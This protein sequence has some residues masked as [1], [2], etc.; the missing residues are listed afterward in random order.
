MPF[1]GDVRSSRVNGFHIR[2]E[3][4][5]KSGGMKTKKSFC[6][7]FPLGTIGLKIILCVSKT[8][9]REKSLKCWAGL[10]LLEL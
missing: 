5:S 1:C 8:E 7:F 3:V 4:K 9:E 6:L 10:T 2:G